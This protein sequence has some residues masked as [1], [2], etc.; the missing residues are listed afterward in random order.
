MSEEAERQ[1]FNPVPPTSSTTPGIGVTWLATSTVA[2]VLDLSTAPGLFGRMLDLYADGG[3]IWFFFSSDGV[4]TISKTTTPAA[5]LALGTVAGAP[6]PIASGGVA[7]V[8]LDATT[9]RYLHF[10]ADAGTPT[11]ILTPSSQTRIF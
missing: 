4:P 2:A 10:Q 1:Y 5:T 9:Q 8:R 6:V 7:T 3:K 11:L